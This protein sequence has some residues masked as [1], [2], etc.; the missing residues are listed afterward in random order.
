MFVPPF[1]IVRSR[2]RG[3][4]ED[5]DRAAMGYPRG[6]GEADAGVQGDGGRVRD[7][8]EAWRDEEACPPSQF[9][10]V[11]GNVPSPAHLLLTLQ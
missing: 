6:A 8:A 10:Q 4:S 2:A 5:Q 9:A 7:E 3:A 1:L 11:H